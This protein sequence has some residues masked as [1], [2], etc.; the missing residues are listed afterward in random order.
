MNKNKWI[1]FTVTKIAYIKR[2]DGKIYFRLEYLD[3]SDDF[4]NDFQGTSGRFQNDPDYLWFNDEAF[5]TSV[6]IILANCIPQE[7]SDVSSNEH[8]VTVPNDMLLQDLINTFVN[9]GVEYL[10]IKTYVGNNIEFCREQEVGQIYSI[11]LV[12]KVYVD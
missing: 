12:F 5:E 9:M 7:Y 3:H 4:H 8:I 6:H 11:E 2:T 10:G 1:D